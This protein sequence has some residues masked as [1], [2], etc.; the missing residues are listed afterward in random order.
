[1]SDSLLQFAERMFVGPVWPAS[2]MVGVMLVYAVIVALGLFDFGLDSG[3]DLDGDIDVDVDVGVDVDADLDADV[4]AEGA[5][6]S[7]ADGG[8]VSGLGAM[9][10]RWLN[11]GKIPI[12]VWLSIFTS[13][14]WAIS[15]AMWYSYDE[16]NYLP[17]LIPNVLLTVR[18]VVFATVITKLITDRMG[19]L[20][21][22]GPSFEA[23][24]L[25]GRTCEVATSEVSTSFGQAKFK[26]DA[27]PL[28]LNIR[29]DEGSL[30]KGT[31]VQIVGF[32]TEKRVYK[33]APTDHESSSVLD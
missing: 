28:L 10:L 23:S 17:T 22:R 21:R 33:V 24:R 29:I 30:P 20:T 3:P 27:A 12:V 16:F 18:N 13:F 15:Y 2:V 31:L 25:I 19:F 14:F 7:A 32:D 1:M 26:T 4:D 6:Q 9:T 8:S 11:L 5:F